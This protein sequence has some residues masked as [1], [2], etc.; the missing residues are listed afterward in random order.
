MR[1]LL[2]LMLCAFVAVLA[3]ALPALDAI[4]TSRTQQLALT[5]SAALDRVAVLAGAA[6]DDREP[7]ALRRYLDRHR[8][9]FGEAV[10]VVDSTGQPIASTGELSPDDP[11]VAPRVVAS[12]RNLPSVD[13]PPVRPWGDRLTL[14]S[15]PILADGDLSRG[16]VVLRVDRREANA[17][18]TLGWA[19][20]LASALAAL[21]LIAALA[22]WWTAWVLR[23]VARLDDAATALAQGRRIR[24]L[25]GSGP[26]ELRHLASSFEAMA[27]TVTEALDQQRG[28]VADASHQLR[29]PLAALRL[30]VD[31]LAHPPITAPDPTELDRIG[32]DLDRLESTVD[33][34]LSLADAEHRASEL[35]AGRGVG[36]VSTASVDGDQDAATAT[37]AERSAAHARTAVAA[38]AAST[39]DL[40]RPWRQL[41]AASGATLLAAPEP[42]WRFGCRRSDL[43]EMLGTLVDNALRY[44]RPGVTVRVE[45]RAPTP[46]LVELAVDDDGPGVDEAD[47]PQLGRRF[48]RAAQH[49]DVRGTGL[50]LAIVEQLAR[51]NEGSLSMARSSRGGLRAAVTL[52]GARVEP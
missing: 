14:I 40:A 27:E 17:D 1:V 48:W 50:G 7:A 43:E 8:E 47:L 11:D 18:V 12:S 10:L 49:H 3:L 25:P 35:A 20:V 21:G 4:A 51:A 31:G 26:P 32:D 28:L 42:V 5:R 34:L 13:I 41:A 15:A 23:P 16:T 44:G 45:C 6:I 9:L 24:E 52:G 30:R 2:P 29:N 33:R 36:A 38:A 19:A 46:G 22:L 37:G 39:E